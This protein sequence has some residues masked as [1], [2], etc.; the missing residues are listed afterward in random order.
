M[1]MD[2]NMKVS[3]L[4]INPMAMVDINGPLENTMKDIGKEGISTEKE[5]K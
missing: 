3:M 1:K 4:M 5:S 2:Q